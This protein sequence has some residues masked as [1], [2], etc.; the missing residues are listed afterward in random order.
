MS[1]YIVENLTQCNRYVEEIKEI[2]NDAAL[3][4]EE[5]DTV[6]QQVVNH[7]Q[8]LEELKSLYERKIESLAQENKSLNK[9]VVNYKTELS[10][11]QGKYKIVNE[12][13]ELLK[14]NSDKTM[15]VQ[16]HVA[17]VD[18]CKRLFEELK[19]QYESEKRK[20]SARIK[21]LEESLPDNEK[22]IVTVTAERNH[23]K[24]LTKTLERNLK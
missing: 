18:E 11:L 17:A 13:Y 4:K 14:V 3:I 23:L 8:K 24:N 6:A 12:G 1:F 7:K 22:E 2:S 20:L 10:N 15:P 5:N 9:D 19:S 16:V 21:Q